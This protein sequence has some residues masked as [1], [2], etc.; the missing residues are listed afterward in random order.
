MAGQVCLKAV[1]TPKIVLTFDTPMTAPFL[2]AYTGHQPVQVAHIDIMPRQL[3]IV[4]QQQVHR[5]LSLLIQP[6]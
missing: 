3:V 6:W 4:E 5:D 1:L 2:T